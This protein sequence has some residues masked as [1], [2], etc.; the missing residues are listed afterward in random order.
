MATFQ[1]WDAAVYVDYNFVTLQNQKPLK[2]G[3]SQHS[4]GELVT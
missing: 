3:I 2:P 4:Y 1:V